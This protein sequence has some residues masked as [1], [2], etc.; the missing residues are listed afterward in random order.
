MGTGEQ[1]AHCV[2]HPSKVPMPNAKKPHRIFVV[3]DDLVIASSLASIL[4][5]QGFDDVTYFTNPLKALDAVSEKTPH[6][7]L[8]DMVMLPFTGLELAMKMQTICPA[9]KII[10]FSGSLSFRELLEIARGEGYD[11]DVLAKPVHP[12]ELMAKIHSGLGLEA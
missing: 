5:Y 3:D 2:W 4:R 1:T 7:L 10:L 12:N 9:C 6:L 8:T 11:F